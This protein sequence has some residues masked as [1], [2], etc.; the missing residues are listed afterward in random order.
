MTVVNNM[1]PDEDQHVGGYIG[2][3]SDVERLT[4]DGAAV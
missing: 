2:F 4:L 3:A 1:Y